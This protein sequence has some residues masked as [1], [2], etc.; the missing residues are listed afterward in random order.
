[1]AVIDTRMEFNTP[2]IKIINVAKV[3][4]EMSELTLGQLALNIVDAK[5]YTLVTSGSNTP[6]GVSEVGRISGDTGGSLSNITGGTFDDG[7][8]TLYS[9]SG[10]D[11][12]IEVVDF[13]HITT[14][15]IS[16]PT[17]AAKIVFYGNIIIFNKDIL[18]SSDKSVN[19]GSQFSRFRSINAYSGNSTYWTS[20]NINSD[21]IN[22]RI[23]SLGVDSVGYIR[24]VN[25]NTSVLKDDNLQGGFY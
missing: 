6:I 23:V 19:I 8:L 25:A 12:R 9:V 5:L 3:V 11:L 10:A 21:T 22:A 15:S 7:Y 13:N 20:T 4:P 14:N 24:E 2:V 18:P 1:M 17:G 16:D